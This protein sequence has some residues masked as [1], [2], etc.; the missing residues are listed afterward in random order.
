[1]ADRPSVLLRA[2]GHPNVRASHGKTFEVTPD[3]AIT[4]AGT[5]ILGVARTV[6]GD[7]AAL[8][9]HVDVTLSCGSVRQTTSGTINP[10]YLAGDPFIFRKDPLPKGNSFAIG[11]RH[12]ASDF[13][14]TLVDALREPDAELTIEAVA[15]QDATQ[16]VVYVVGVP[17]G[18]DEDLSPR[19][20]RVLAGVDIIACEDTRTSRPLL[21][22]VGAKAKRVSYH[23]HN[24]KERARELE[25]ALREGARIAVISDA[26]VPGVADP[27]HRLVDLAHEA[28]AIVSPIPGPSA[29]LLAV[30]AS[31]LGTDRFTFEGFLPRGAQARDE[32]LARMAARPGASIL[33]EAPHRLEATLNAIAAVFEER[34]VVVAR[35]LTKP[36]EE[37]LRAPASAILAALTEGDRLRGE[38]TIVLPGAAAEAASDETPDWLEPMCRELL[39][40]RVPTKAIASAIRAATGWPKKR[41]Y[42]YVVALAERT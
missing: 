10:L 23:D 19:A 24:E 34:P 6:E 7:P 36:N 12:A 4:Q 13:D 42:D 22:G 11:C 9:G 18:N 3:E 29:A 17:L 26:G 16:G 20:R 28:G 30:V 27:G 1:M 33:Y 8:R 41:G 15:R 2:R 31:G 5:C 21:N 40:A 38:I 39:A 32:A 14:R 25:R 35:E 37:V